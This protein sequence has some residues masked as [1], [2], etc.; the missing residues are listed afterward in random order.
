MNR[1]YSV[2][3]SYLKKDYVV[4][5]ELVAQKRATSSVGNATIVAFTLISLFGGPALAQETSLEADN[6]SDK[7]IALDSIVMLPQNSINEIVHKSTEEEYALEEEDEK[8]I[9]KIRLANSQP[10]I[11]LKSGRL[12][13]DTNSQNIGSLLPKN[14][15]F[16]IGEGATIDFSSITNSSDTE[17]YPNT[18]VGAMAIG[19][20]AISQ[21]GRA[22]AIGQEAKATTAD[23]L[24][25]G[26]KAQSGITSDNVTYGRASIAIGKGAQAYFDS[27]IAIGDGAK[28]S[29]NKGLGKETHHLKSIAIGASATAN[30]K[31]A[32]ALGSSAS[33]N[34]ESAVAIGNGATTAADRGIALGYQA[35]SGE[36]TPG[37][38]YGPNAIA[39][40]AES[41]ARSNGSIA[42]GIKS[43]TKAV[44]S[45][46]IGVEATVKDGATWG[47]AIGHKATSQLTDAIA[48]GASSIAGK[49]AIS[50]GERSESKAEG[51]VA[52]GAKSKATLEN[53]VS[54]GND[55][56]QRKLVNVADGSVKKDSKEAVTGG[57]LYVL[58][59]GVATVLGG[60]AQFDNGVWTAPDFS[61]ALGAKEG[62]IKDV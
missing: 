48:I 18:I 58:G 3:W 57:Q 2:V 59:T 54:F 16:T 29:S 13:D 43:N 7:G 56:L 19:Y 33:V 47:I 35:R 50:I 6:I 34:G 17:L 30:H 37:M 44:N 36:D 27:S 8:Q 62:T 1:I 42:I 41:F 14:N 9:K 5:S 11:L 26:Y 51:S 15:A 24:A 53:T 31:F 21:H 60:G 10:S 4:T 55:T 38:L 49:G 12:I 46:A 39:I 20:N 52:I 28:V 40:G 22:I 25:L 45:V 23:G 61:G 32:I